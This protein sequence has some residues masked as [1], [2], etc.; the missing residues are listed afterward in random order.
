MSASGTL[1]RLEA[2]IDASGV[3]GRIEALLPVGVRPRQLSVRTL[4][5][6]MLVVAVD[7]RPAHLRRVHE[8]LTGLPERERRRLGVIAQWKEGPHELSY[9]QVERT[10]ALV[11]GAL[12]KDEPDGQP[13]ELLQEVL[14]RLLEASVEV[15]GEAGSSSYAVDWTDLESWSRPPPKHGGEG[16]DPEASW[17]HRRGDSPGERDEAFFG[18]Y[19][20]AATI[21]RD[22]RGPEVPERVRRIQI[23]SCDVDPP[24]AFVAVIGR[25]VAESIAIC[26]LLADSGY[27][28]RGAESWALPLRRLGVRLVQD[29]HPHD[30]G[31]N[32]THMGAIL[33]NGNLYCPATPKALLELSP[34]KRGG[35]A[36]EVAAHDRLTGELSKYK[37]GRISGYD[38]DGYHRVACPAA[39]GKLRCPLRPA[40]LALPHTRPQVLRPPDSPPACCRQQTLTVPPQVNAKTA[41]KHD[42]PSR[43]HRRSYARRSA[44]E[45][46]YAS[47]KDP[48]TNDL[49]RGWCRLMGLTPIALFTASVFVARNLRIV[50]AFAARQADERR[51]AAC[52]FAPRRRKRRR[53]TAEHLID[54]ANAPP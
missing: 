37:L 30:R 51:R 10:F 33:A 19:L 29:L 17:G 54:A 38:R 8:A 13:S 21:I 48:A 27:S 50:A 24:P 35:S 52:G 36:E 32:G 25:M 41:Q 14:D 43:A 3:A 44:A 11:V 28:Y 42:Y 39:Q 5:V 31:P 2:I 47:V 18:Y 7:G 16:A 34:L 15:L 9:R 26:D 40:S 6:G 1:P 4:L 20:Q 46:A 12:A 49:S 22:E 23:A 53:Q 45:R